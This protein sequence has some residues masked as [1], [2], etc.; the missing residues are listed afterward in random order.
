MLQCSNIE[1]FP[2]ISILLSHCVLS[3]R[4]S[5]YMHYFDNPKG[6]IPT[7]LINWAA[8]V[9]VALN[10]LILCVLMVV[11]R[12]FSSFLFFILLTRDSVCGKFTLPSPRVPVGSPSRGGD[13]AV[14]V[15]DINQPSLPTS[16]YSVLVCIF[17]P[18]V[19]LCG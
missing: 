16:F 8:K 6:N 5:A 14:Y 13:V 1:Q 4:F 12:F 2:S 11:F 10:G 15:F 19:I 18:D 3:P 17:S 9:R 7:W